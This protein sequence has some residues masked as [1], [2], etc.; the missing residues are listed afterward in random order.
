M[1]REQIEYFFEAFNADLRA[2]VDPEEAL[3]RTAREYAYVFFGDDD[4]S[5]LARAASFALAKLQ[6]ETGDNAERS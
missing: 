1:T 5:E 3:K 6:R 2:G 4:R